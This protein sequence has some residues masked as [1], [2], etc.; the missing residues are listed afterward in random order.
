ME[1]YYLICFLSMFYDFLSFFSGVIPK[2]TNTQHINENIL[3]DF[4]LSS[5]SFNRLSHIEGEQK[6]G[7]NPAGI[8]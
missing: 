5:D 1:S 3:L 2:S 6:F 4:E 7:W 8:I